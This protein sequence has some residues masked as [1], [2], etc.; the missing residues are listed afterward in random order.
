MKSL[1]NFI[2]ESLK[3]DNRFIIKRN[4]LNN[5]S[6]KYLDLLFNKLNAKMNYPTEYVDVYDLKDIFKDVAKCS[7]NSITKK[8][9]DYLSK[10]GGADCD[11]FYLTGPYELQD[12][13]D[14]YDILGY[15]G[16]IYYFGDSKHYVEISR[17]GNDF[18]FEGHNIN[19][20]TELISQNVQ[21]HTFD[22]K[23]F[24]FS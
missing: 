14:D 9:L 15:Y 23:T 2:N 17:I 5:E 4:E 7:N 1:I 20:P 16:N 19:M 11:L 21:N 10:K 3:I 18:Y 13:R 8:V 24:E 12:Y 6:A 22:K